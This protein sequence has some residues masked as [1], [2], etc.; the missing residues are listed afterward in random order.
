M[1]KQ[2][3]RRIGECVYCG[4]VG[5]LTEDHIP[6][7]NLFPK[8]RPANLISVPSCDSCNGGASKDDEYFRLCL[9]VVENAKGQPARDAVFPSVLRSL[10]RPEAKGFSTSFWNDTA[11]ADRLSPSGLWGTGTLHAAAGHRMDRVAVRIVKGLFF[12]ETRQRVP[13]DHAVRPL[14]V[15]RLTGLDPNKRQAVE[16][17]IDALLNT[18]TKRIGDVF[19]FS[20]LWSQNGWPRCVWLLEFYRRVE[21]FIMIWPT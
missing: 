14:H 8:P 17:F 5:P 3:K 1:R 21:Y 13:D 16:G 10:V 6:P 9:T 4:N 15:S 18:Q 20:R 11:R 12:S 19:A 7:Q 2:K